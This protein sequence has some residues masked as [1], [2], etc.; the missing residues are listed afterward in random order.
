LYYIIEADDYD[1]VEKFLVPGF[2]HCTATI[3]PVSQFFGE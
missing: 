3:A 2:K 1:I